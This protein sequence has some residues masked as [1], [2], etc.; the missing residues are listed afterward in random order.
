MLPS[1]AI[2]NKTSHKTPDE[3]ARCARSIDWQIRMN[4]APVWGF[5]ATVFAAKEEAALP[6]TTW[7]VFLYEELTDVL[8][9]GRL[10]YHDHVGRDAVPRG[11]VFVGPS[12]RADELWTEIVSHEVIEML[13][14]P[15]VNLE[16]ARG[17]ELWPRELCD[18][19][20]GQY[21]RTPLIEGVEVANFVYPEYF[22]EGSDGPY[23]HLGRLSR[24]FSVAP[25][26]YSLVTKGGVTK[27]TYGEGYPS[28]RREPRLAS[29]R[30]ERYGAHS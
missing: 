5:F 23:D 3:V 18:A 8:E 12:E 6:P 1:I 17:D 11:Y 20:Q 24:P 13:G 10:G 25:T 30:A 9:A 2:I 16:V 22:L 7:R 29:R 21:Y 19:V 27:P 15:W 4:V 28:W 26:G 14:D